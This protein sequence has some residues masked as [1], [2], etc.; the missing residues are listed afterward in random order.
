MKVKK[1][2]GLSMFLD[3]MTEMACVGTKPNEESM[4]YAQASGSL[5]CRCM[6]EPRYRQYRMRACEEEYDVCS[7]FPRSLIAESE[8]YTG[9]KGGSMHLMIDLVKMLGHVFFVP[10]TV[11]EFDTYCFRC[12]TGEA[13]ESTNERFGNESYESEITSET[14]RNVEDGMW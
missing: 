9:I 6:T 11:D 2:Y 3:Y 8:F 7:S 14:C 4:E 13:Q 5:L 12:T 10:V 1:S